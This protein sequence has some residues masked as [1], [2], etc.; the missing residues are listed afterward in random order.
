[1]L[2]TDFK[3]PGNIKVTIEHYRLSVWGGNAYEPQND[4]EVYA[5]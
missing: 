5:R 4:L 2:V 3:N 1:M